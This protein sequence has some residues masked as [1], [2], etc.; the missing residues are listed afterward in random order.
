[1]DKKRFILFGYMAY[2]PCGGMND[3]MISFDTEEELINESKSFQCDYY[4]VFD[5]ETF[6][7]ASDYSPIKAFENLDI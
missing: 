7:T 4:N 2:Y 5:T 1:M 6:K 3:S